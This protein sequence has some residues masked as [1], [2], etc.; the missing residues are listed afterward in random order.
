M[1]RSHYVALAAMGAGTLAM[2]AIFSGDLEDDV[3]IYR[4]ADHCKQDGKIPAEECETSYAAARR[5][6]QTSAPSYSDDAK[7][8]TE[9]SGNCEKMPVPWVASLVSFTLA[10]KSYPTLGTCTAESANTQ[11]ACADAYR[12]ALLTHNAVTK[13][14]ASQA[15]CEAVQGTGNCNELINVAKTSGTTSSS[16]STYRPHWYYYMFGR[17]TSY[18]P[19]QP[20]YHSRNA[21]M[22]FR[23]ADGRHVGSATGVRRISSYAS[24]P[25]FSSSSSTRSSTA[26][27]GGFGSSTGS[28]G[29]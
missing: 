27:R 3:A 26:S 12:L 17:N 25:G 29:G 20:L 11:Q 5:S 13:R 1:K 14:H 21:A 28:T 9:H 7:C 16:S 15:E 10:G 22:G 8:K 4:D 23:T 24:R 19:S 2:I 18:V 6:H